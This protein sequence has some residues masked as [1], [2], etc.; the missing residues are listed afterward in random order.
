LDSGSLQEAEKSSKELK[1]FGKGEKLC[2][3]Q[4]QE[5]THLRRSRRADDLPRRFSNAAILDSGRT[6]RLAGTAEQAEIQVI[7]EALVKLNAPF[8]GST[9][10]MYSAA[11]RFGFQAKCT[12]RRTL[13]QTQTAVDALIEFGKIQC[14]DL[15]TIALLLF[16]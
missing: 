1:A 4:A 7:L 5:E 13:I 15:R 14:R 9:D 8:S 11:R 2:K 3:R 16:V 10:Q 6:S 12:V